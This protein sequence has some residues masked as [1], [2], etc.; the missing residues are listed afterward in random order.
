LNKFNNQFKYSSE[1]QVRVLQ[2]GVVTCNN[3]KVEAISDPDVAVLD[4]VSF[5]A[6]VISLLVNG[7]ATKPIMKMTNEN[8]FSI[9]GCLADSQ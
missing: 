6:N 3:Y 2:G 7:W 4:A 9:I 1:L 8:R 5:Y